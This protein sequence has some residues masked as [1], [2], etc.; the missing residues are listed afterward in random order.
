MQSAVITHP[1]DMM[2]L[3]MMYLLPRAHFLAVAC[4]FAEMV[5]SLLGQMQRPSIT[6]RHV[7][8]KTKIKYTV[9]L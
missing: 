8:A 7:G 4:A 3:I 1:L 9:L 2:A 6:Q 5:P